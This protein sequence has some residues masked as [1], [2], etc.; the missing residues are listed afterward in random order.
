MLIDGWKNPVLYA[1]VRSSY[2]AY[3]LLSP[4]HSGRPDGSRFAALICPD[5]L[6]NIMRA[7]ICVSWK[8][9]DDMFEFL[10]CGSL[11]RRL[12][13]FSVWAAFFATISRPLTY[14]TF[15]TAEQENVEASLQVSLWSGHTQRSHLSVTACAY[16]PNLSHP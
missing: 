8:I 3:F 1:P 7:F 13:Q 5:Q 4:C 10:F 16:L 14:L 2:A 9:N 15:L 11:K 6:K 12:I